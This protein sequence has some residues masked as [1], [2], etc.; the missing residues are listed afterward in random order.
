LS[1]VAALVAVLLAATAP[2]WGD[3]VVF[4]VGEVAEVLDGTVEIC[5]VATGGD[6]AQASL[7][8]S[9]LGCAAADVK[10]YSYA[11]F[12]V[13][14]GE[15]IEAPAGEEIT[16]TIAKNSTANL[17][18]GKQRKGDALIVEFKD[19]KDFKNCEL[20]VI[21]EDK[22]ITVGIVEE[23]KILIM[24]ATAKDVV[25]FVKCSK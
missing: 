19:R 4:E 21:S 10:K 7:T 18:G 6:T 20:K 2:A 22:T 16:A 15:L 23:N 1:L 5:D 25:V 14:N 11:G 13:N 9:A 8:E 12:K 3:D 24:P 17:P